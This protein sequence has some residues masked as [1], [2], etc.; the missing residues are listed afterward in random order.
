VTGELALAH[1]DERASQDASG[2]ATTGASGAPLKSG[3]RVAT[4]PSSTCAGVRAAT[5]AASAPSRSGRVRP[6]LRA[7]SRQPRGAHSRGWR[8]RRLP[9]L[10]VQ[11]AGAQGTAVDIVEGTVFQARLGRL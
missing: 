7:G 6:H 9:R 3:A 2:A 4:A 5:T 10:V 8:P 11:A 1:A